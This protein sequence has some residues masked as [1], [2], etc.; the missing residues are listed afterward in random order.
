M[1]YGTFLEQRYTV[2]IVRSVAA[3]G[4]AI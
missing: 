3:A 4:R 1:P 2:P